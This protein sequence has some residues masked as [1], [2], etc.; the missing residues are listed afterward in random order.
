[1]ASCIRESG[2]QYAG[3]GC[4]HL[5]RKPCIQGQQK[6]HKDY[7]DEAADSKKPAEKVLAKG[8]LYGEGNPNLE[9]FDQ[10]LDEKKPRSEAKHEL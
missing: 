5:L 2:E 4:A 7:S 1:L 6:D 10:R 8:S 9:S 3:F